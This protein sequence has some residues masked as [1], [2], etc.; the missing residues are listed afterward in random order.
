MRRPRTGISAQ[1]LPQLVRQCSS[2][3]L[4]DGSLVACSLCR[5]TDDLQQIFDVADGWIGRK[6]WR[7]IFSLVSLAYC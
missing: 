3:L 2:V 7:C 6:Y 4:M 5:A 1:E